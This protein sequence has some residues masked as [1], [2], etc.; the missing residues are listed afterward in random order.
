MKLQKQLT[1]K[2]AAIWSVIF[3][4]SVF[5]GGG[6]GKT[7]LVKQT[8]S[9]DEADVSFE[10]AGEYDIVSL[11]NATFQDDEEGTPLLPSV[12]VN[13]LVPA[14]STVI[15]VDSVAKDEVL[16]ATGVFPY[17][18]QP[19]S[20]LDADI[21][22]VFVGPKAEAYKKTK[23]KELSSKGKTQTARE[24]TVVPVRLNPLR[25]VPATGELYLA[26]KVEVTVTVEKPS[27]RP[28]IKA[29]K[30][31]KEFV[32]SIQSLVVNPEES[33][34][35]P[36][37]TDLTSTDTTESST[38]ALEETASALL[39]TD[40]D[41]LVITK[42]ALRPA[43]QVLANHRTSFKGLSSK[44]ISVEQIYT[45]YTGKDNQTKIR[46]CIKDYVTNHGTLY[47]CLGG[48]SLVVP[49]R[50]CYV[51]CGSYVM[52]KMPTDL[53]YAGLDGT[54]DEDGDSVYGE[55]NTLVGDEGDLLAD[56]WVGRIPVQTAAQASGYINKLIAF[57]TNPPTAIA[58]KF[59]TGGQKLWDSYTLTSRPGD[60]MNDGHAQ[61]QAANHPTV[62]DSEIW[63]RRQYRDTVQSTGWVP[64]QFACLI[65]TI[66]SWDGA[67]NCGYYS[68]GGNNLVTRLSEGW[69]FAFWVTH[70]HGNSMNAESDG[71]ELSH[72]NALTGLTAFFYTGSCHT[73]AFDTMEPSLSEAMLR[74]PN[75]GALVYLGCSR[76]NWGGTC[77]AYTQ[78]FLR[79]VF[80]DQVKNAAKA[81][82]D[83]K[84]AFIAYSGT[85]GSYRWNM[86]GI[87]YQGDPAITITGTGLSV[88]NVAPVAAN[89][90]YSVAEGATL[91]VTA[92][93]GVLKN[94]TDANGN[95]LSA[96]RVALPAHG[97][98]TFNADGSFVYKP[99]VG[100]SGPDSFTYKAYDGSLYSNVAT[101]TLTVTSTVTNQ[102][103]V[104]VGNTYSVN[105]GTVLSISSPGVLSNDTDGD[106]DALTAVLATNAAHG[107]VALN[108]N[109]SFSYTPAAGYAGADS[110]TYKA[111]DG[112]STSNTATVGIT[113][114]S[115]GSGTGNVVTVKALDSSSWES[116]SDTGSFK[117]TR[118][119]DL[120][121]SLTVQYVM[122]GTAVNGTDYNTVSGSVT[123]SAGA[124]YAFVVIKPIDDALVEGAEGVT[125]K[126]SASASY[127]LG[128]VSSA[129]LKIYDSELPVVSI[130][131]TDATASEAPNYGIFTVT[132]TGSTSAS[133]TVNY[134]ISGAATNGV[135]YTALSG[136]VTIPA[137]S[138][139]A[140]I[141]L[142]PVNDSLMESN[143][144][145]KISISSS[146][147]Y[148]VGASYAG[149]IYITDND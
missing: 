134:S 15:G 76:Y 49:D 20:P 2:A 116:G 117:V 52:S 136:S 75:G 64:S 93:N 16:V 108:S 5:A 23:K 54:W 11:K 63:L 144:S 28:Q 86:F 12:Y 148:Q 124:A 142:K 37:T 99:V 81:F 34:G 85:N 56:V 147:S 140:V 121:A 123:V 135:D 88:V 73:G 133:L 46:N 92:T 48:D 145:V 130:N 67:N 8:F 90:A 70:G 51:T 83:H 24:M 143:E 149:T 7:H 80:K 94:D 101:V 32:A 89:N 44:V 6:G 128:S 114:V 87:N 125:L 126:L 115:S 53:Y 18:V 9:Y 21:K 14:G 129:S 26:R 141:T 57:E 69:N 59:I 43:F 109:G 50:D 35:L 131:E 22:P 74:N 118:T 105:Q 13:I 78:G 4:V 96:V 65:D 127:T 146:T 39:A 36:L 33:E 10:Q 47:V 119:G 31:H 19:P 79:T 139:S 112:K 3:S 45:S 38:A 1:L 27:K 132:R 17:P 58:R 91:T 103:P 42:E 82:Y 71:F 104:A 66:T 55:A 68:A 107:T 110:F 40:C 120:A 122:S 60:L 84:A 62:S 100:Y 113:V 30:K 137:G 98:L 111:S 61:F 106:G 29:G 97:S 138:A 95:A 72:A 41:Y 25:I 77:M 102:V